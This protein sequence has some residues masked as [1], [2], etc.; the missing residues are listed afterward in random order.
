MS[1]G[2][3]RLRRRERPRE[4][5]L[6]AEGR[7]AQLRDARRAERQA[8]H[9]LP[10]A[11]HEPEPRAREG[12]AVVTPEEH[13]LAEPPPRPPLIGPGHTFGS[14]TDKISAIVLGR[15]TPLAWF[16]GFGVGF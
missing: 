10:R 6:E 15:R 2:G 13:A 1:R 3:H 16:I 7:S 12:D 5:G 9:H 4:P 14:I 8:A 11:S